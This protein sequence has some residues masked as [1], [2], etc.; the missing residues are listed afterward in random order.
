MRRVVVFT[1]VCLLATGTVMAQTATGAL[2]G[3]AVDD[4]GQALPGVSVVVTSDSLQG[5]RATVTDENG[6]FN[7]PVLP[8]G[9]YTATF[10][11]PGFQTVN[12]EEVKISIETSITIDVT[13]TSSFSDEVIVTSET[14]VIDV[15]TP[16]I[17]TNLDS[18]SLEGLPTGR[19][20]KSVTY[21]ATG[22]VDGGGLSN[23]AIGGA[24]SIMGASALEN[25]Y[26]V[27]ELDTTDPAYGLVGS[28]VPLNFIEEVQVKTG[29]YEAEYGGALGGVINMITK[30]GSNEFHGDL[31]GYFSNDSLWDDAL[32]PETRGDVKTTK[33]DW[34]VGFT[35]G[36]KI[37]ADQ[38][39]FFVAYN[40]NTLDQ[41]ITKDVFDLSGDAVQSNEFVRSYQKDYFTGKLTWQAGRSNALT[42][43]VIG[44]PGTTENDFTQT[45]TNYVNSPFVDDTNMLYNADT[46]GINYG[47][48]WNGILNDKMFLEAKVGHHASQEQFIPLLDTTNYADQT[49][50]GIWS[51]GI[52]QDVRFGGANFQQPLDERT[53]N[54]I[55]GAF[56]WFAGNTHEVKIGAGYSAVEFDMN[57]QV[58]GPSDAFCAPVAPGGVFAYDILTGDAYQLANN[59]SVNGD[60]TLDGYQMPARVGNR[61]RLRDGYYYNRNYKNES[62]GETDETNLYIQDA[63]QVTNNFTINAGL[64]FSASHSTG[65]SSGQAGTLPGLNTEID[66]GFGDMVAPRLGFVW[67][68]STTGKSKVYAHYGKFYQ[69]IPLDINVRAFGAESYDFYYYYY[70]ENGLLPSVDNPGDLTYIYNLVNTQVDPDLEPQYLEE[71][72]LGGEYEVAPNVAVG[73]KF[74]RRELGEVI[75]DISVDRGNTYFITNPG[76]TYEVNPATGVELDEPAFFPPATRKYDAVELSLVKR[77]TNNWQLSSSILW[78]N[79]EGNYE[80]LYSRDNAQIDPNITSKFDIPSLLENADGLLQNH[81][82]WQFK[83]YGAYHFDFGLVTGLNMYY[84]TGNPYSKLGADRSYGLDERFVTQRGSEGFTED[85]LNFDLHLAYAL[86]LGNNQIEFILDVFNVF[87]NQVAVEVD[88]RW[89]TLDPSQY[90]GG[91]APP[92]EGDDQWQNN[93]TWGEPLTYALPRNL[94]FG[95]KFSW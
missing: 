74:V 24:P 83:T 59:C 81:R 33:T 39:W 29:G 12:Q 90:P 48:S 68:P 3:T 50:E 1:I 32:V 10:S 42:L 65:D 46:G 79:L 77:Y 80:G 16:A 85:W 70:P 92:N 84:M 58:A 19:D 89:T 35:L 93:P 21:L 63:W 82:E 14:P 13:M 54:Q 9:V 37:I 7:I 6:R 69:A 66:F 5:N 71:F 8:V 52:A 15:T 72:V 55:R 40:P 28:I 30:S 4:G 67:D 61:F 31:F 44:D 23:D 20:F 76:G 17:G 51:N 38:L 88:Q 64:R 45:T 11:L 53:R 18:R 41:N 49:G 94:R 47:L 86:P 78:S 36:G 25:R 43:S 56:T 62:T 73:L 2:K 60:G 91:E 95:V 22:A 26:V 87:D 75:E 34:D 57:Y 27:D